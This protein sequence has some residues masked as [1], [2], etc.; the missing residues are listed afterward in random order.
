[1]VESAI[2][3]W[4]ALERRER[5]LVAGG[6]LVLL[7]AALWFLMFEPAWNGRE[8]LRADL[9]QLR[10]QVAR[11]DSLAAEVE[12]LSQVR[13][14]DKAPAVV[15]EELQRSLTAAGLDTQATIDAG[16]DVLKVKIDQAKFETVLSW[17]YGA[18]RDVKLRVVDASLVRGSQPGTVNATIGLET[19]GASR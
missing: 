1:M 18:V 19:P 3:W 8:R 5:R 10:E 9:P 13:G 16:S 7:L 2:T 11:M 12:T 14:K 17:L 15:R 6:S 4:R